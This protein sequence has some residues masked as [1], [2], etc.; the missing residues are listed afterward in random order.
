MFTG[1][2]EEVGA[3]RAVSRSGPSA[4]LCVRAAKVLEGTQIGDSIAV[5]GVCLTARPLA[6][7][8]RATR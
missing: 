1:I 4:R 2:V 7:C 8:G 6:A 5:N 3:L